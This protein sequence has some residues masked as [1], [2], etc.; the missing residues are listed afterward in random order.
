MIKISIVTPIRENL[1]E[2]ARLMDSIKNT[3]ETPSEIE[4]ILIADKCDAVLVPLI[5]RLE[6][7]YKKFNLR[8]FIVY[9]SEH[10]V[11]DYYNFAAKQAIGRWILAINADVV[12]MTPSWDRIID[13]K[14]SAAA[15]QFK[16]DFIYGITKDGL[17]RQGDPGIETSKKAIWPQKVDFSCWILTSKA[18]VNFYGGMMDELNWLWGADHWTGL[19]WQNVFQ[20]SRIVMILEVFIDHISHHVKDLPQPESF[21]YFCAIMKKHGF[22]YTQ[23]ISQKEARKIENHINKI[24]Q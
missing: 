11:R 4:I 14:M 23:A 7:K 12:F 13:S 18:F 16:D 8:F 10:F 19:M 6:R 20:G 17:P 15:D 21:K 1:V 5:P 22:S 2:L 24:H 9:R 3:T